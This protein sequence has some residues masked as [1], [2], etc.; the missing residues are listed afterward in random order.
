MVRT[1]SGS[2]VRFQSKSLRFSVSEGFTL[3]EVL[4]GMA[5]LGITFTVLF[6]LL[7]GSLRNIDRIGE[8]EKILRLARMKLNELIV[9]TN[10]GNIIPQSAGQ[11]NDRYH[12]KASIATLATQEEQETQPQRLPP[13]LLAQIK[14]SVTWTSREHEVEFPLETTTWMPVVEKEEK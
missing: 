11:W 7:S 10:Q 2:R 6:G 5:I 1:K 14:L 8:R 3:M 9:Q 13:Y 12:W 4:V